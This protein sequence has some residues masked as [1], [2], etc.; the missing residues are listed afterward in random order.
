MALAQ[1]VAAVALSVAGE[2][3]VACK[4]KFFHRRPSPGRALQAGYLI[5]RDLSF[6]PRASAACCAAGTGSARAGT[7]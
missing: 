3:S 6:L 5:C 1:L 7:G 2:L 4:G